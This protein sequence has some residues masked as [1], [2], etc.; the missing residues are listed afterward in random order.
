MAKKISA[1]IDKSILRVIPNAGHLSN[2][3][4]PKEFNRV[5]LSFL[6]NL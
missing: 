2:I 6:A 3:E 4:N 5:V 1:N